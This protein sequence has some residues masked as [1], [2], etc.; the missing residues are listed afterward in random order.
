MAIF[1]ERCNSCHS[2]N[3][4]DDIWVVAPNGVIFDNVHQIAQMKDRIML[5]V[6]TTETMPLAN[7]TNMTDEE[8]N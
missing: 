1:Q 6:V 2:S 3:P 8:R 4:V 5:R 7:Q